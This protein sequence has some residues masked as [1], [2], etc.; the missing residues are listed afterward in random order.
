MIRVTSSAIAALAIAGCVREV[1]AEEMYCQV[2]LT[3]MTASALSNFDKPDEKVFEVT[4]LTSGDDQTLRGGII[5]DYGYFT[6]YGGELT[7]SEKENFEVTKDGTCKFN[8]GG[9]RISVL[10]L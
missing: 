1:P 3:E 2:D 5:N 4:D 6:M 8:R 9:V 10:Q 7:N